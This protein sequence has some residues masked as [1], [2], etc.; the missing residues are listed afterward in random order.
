MSS[1]RSITALLLSNTFG[2]IGVASGIAVGALLVASMGGDHLAGTGQAVSIFGAA[3][4]AVPL[5]NLASRR[6]RRLALALGYVIA[7]AGAVVVLIGAWLG[8]LLLVLA[9]LVAFGAAQATNLQSRYAAADLAS[10]DRRATLMSIVLW[11]TTI[12]S[13]VGPNLS[14]AGA[15]LGSG[16]RL[17]ELAGP[18]L[19]S[20]AGFALAGVAIV[21][22]YRGNPPSAAPALTATEA[23]PASK[24]GAVAALRWA[25]THPVARFAV[26]LIVVGHA[27]M[28]GVMSMTPVH[29]GH[30]GHGLSAIGLVISLHIMGMYALS[31]VVG[32]LAD[33]FGAMRTAAVGL[34]L[35]ASTA[36][37]ILVAPK[38][39]PLVTVALVLLGVGWSFTMISGSA[40]LARTNSGDMRVPLQGATDALMNYAGAAAALIGGPVLAWLGYGGLALVA[41]VLILPAGGMGWVARRSRTRVAPSAAGAKH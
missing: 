11:A 13:V 41:A 1:R 20:V 40:L 32:W 38:S 25:A 37:I 36:G 19:F 26:L 24:T 31:P 7:A 6:G 9:G 2:G 35:L 15:A 3:L 21:A 8:S 16:I 39:F 34:L 29:L 30:E 14:G 5:A 10:P 18:Y 23:V 12:G 22:L 17:P 4:L 27:V 28:V 33:R